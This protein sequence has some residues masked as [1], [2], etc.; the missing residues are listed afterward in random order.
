VD[1]ILFPLS[2]SAAEPGTLLEDFR[3]RLRRT[4]WGHETPDTLLAPVWSAASS[5]RRFE[6]RL[7]A[8][9]RA[10]LKV[11][12]ALRVGVSPSSRWAQYARLLEAVRAY[13]LDW[14]ALGH[15]EQLSPELLLSDQVTRLMFGR[16]DII[17]AQDGPRVVETNFDTAVGG[18][19]RPNDMWEIAAELFTPPA[20]CL[21]TGQPVDGLRQYFSELAGGAPCQVHWI[22]KNDEVIRRVLDAM[23][24]TLDQNPH[25]VK[26]FIHYAGD[27][28]RLSR[29]D[30][31]AYLHR[32]CSI[33]TVNRDRERFS[34][35]LA[36]LAP[37]V[38]GSTV[39]VEL[40]LLDSKLF[41]AWLSDPA[42]R[43][44][45]LTA[46]ERE[47]VEGLVPWTRVLS[48][49]EG[50][51]LER[52]RRDRGDFILKKADSYQ[53]RDV[54]FGCNLRGDEWAALVEARLREPPQLAGA[55]NIW[56]IQE[57]VRPRE[58]SLLEYTDVGPVERRTGLSCCP[59][60]LGGRLRGLETWVTPFT[61]DLTMIHRM[62][63]VAHF[64]RQGA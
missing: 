55:S 18:Y 22:M 47:A 59:Y 60:V 10:H 61:P 17:L 25:G 54:Y 49:L 2:F 42:A 45:T 27:S 36:Q 4:R 64:I 8:L 3:A 26:H 48:L 34:A 28:V 44:T 41:L 52:V 16:P 32:A 50:E 56:I 21:V 6:A 12:H 37:V 39:P 38:R 43:P 46:E 7:V 15:G 19:D 62:Q 33:F 13:C 31:P 24:A 30:V 20:D 58:F 5:L 57:R 51:E 29:G 11:L 9:F 35:L 53:A 63:F 1:P 23:L 14:P 40:S